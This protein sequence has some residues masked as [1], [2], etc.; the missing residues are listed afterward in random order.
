[1]AQEKRGDLSDMPADYTG[2]HSLCG[3]CTKKVE[4]PLRLLSRITEKRREHNQTTG[5]V[6]TKQE[7]CFLAQKYQIDLAPYQAHHK[8]HVDDTT[9]PCRLK[10]RGRKDEERGRATKKDTADIFELSKTAIKIA[11]A[12]NSKN[13]LRG[14]FNLTEE[15]IQ[16]ALE[17][18]L[19]A[20]A[21]TD[22]QPGSTDA[23]AGHAST[24]SGNTTATN[25]QEGNA[26]TH[27][28]IGYTY[29]GS[30]KEITQVSTKKRKNG[31]DSIPALYSAPFANTTQFYTPETTNS[32]FPHSP[33]TPSDN[34]Q[35][36]T[37]QIGDPEDYCENDTIDFLIL[38]N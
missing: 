34:I 10:E 36:T 32:Q 30:Y 37:P 15:G 16:Q 31:E 11:C 26:C 21:S 18:R 9:T 1:M 13:V 4:E 27:E 23:Q 35:S 33:T 28:G 5:R 3:Y 22:T 17:E 38:S 24:H 29:A 8:R 19:N 2:P 6:Q 12:P 7:I 20:A 14:M 25:A